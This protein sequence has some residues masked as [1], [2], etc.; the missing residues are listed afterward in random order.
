MSSSSSRNKDFLKQSGRVIWSLLGPF[1]TITLKCFTPIRLIFFSDWYWKKPPPHPGIV[2]EHLIKYSK[3]FMARSL[4]SCRR[5]KMNCGSF[6][7]YVSVIHWW[8]CM[9]KLILY[10]QSLNSHLRYIFLSTHKDKGRTDKKNVATGWI[11]VPPP[12]HLFM[13]LLLYP[14]I[15]LF[16]PFFFP[17]LLIFDDK[18]E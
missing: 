9:L 5:P 3:K 6:V 14:K 17:L 4:S 2:H 12:H 1:T 8:K 16:G 13:N 7:Y 10:V 18:K 15:R 11:S